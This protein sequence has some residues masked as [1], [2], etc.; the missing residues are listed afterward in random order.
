MAV[1]DTKRS[2]QSKVIAGRRGVPPEAFGDVPGVLII[3]VFP[4]SL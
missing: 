4:T 3:E 2:F 1:T